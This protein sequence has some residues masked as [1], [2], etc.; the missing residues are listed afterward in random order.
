MKE[1]VAIISRQKLHE[2]K[3]ALDGLGF[4]HCL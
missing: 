4:S 2:T 1:I 3:T